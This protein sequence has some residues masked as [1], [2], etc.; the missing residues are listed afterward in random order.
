[1]LDYRRQSLAILAQHHLHVLHTGLWCHAGLFNIAFSGTDAAMFTTVQSV[2]LQ[3]CQDMHGAME[4]CHGIGVR[5]APLME[6]EHGVGLEVLRRLK[7]CFDPQN[8]SNPGKLDLV[9]VH[10]S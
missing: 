6:R 2:L 5:L 3:L 9:T 1:M 8:I 10:T 7:Q 4:Y